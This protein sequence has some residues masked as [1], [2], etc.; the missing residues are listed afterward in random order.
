MLVVVLSAC[1]RTSAS[2]NIRPPDLYAGG[3]TVGDVRA[4]LG[5]TNWWPGPPSFGVR[6][7]NSAMT[8]IHERFSVTQR[9][10]HIGTTETF[11]AQYTLWDTTSSATTQMTTIQTAF[12]TSVTGPKE[13]DQVLYYGSQAS[14][15]APY[16][17]ATFVRVGQIVAG[18]D[19]S[20]KDGFPTVSQLG[21]IA[22]KAASRIKDA[23]ATKV[24]PSPLTI[25]DSSL[26]PPAGPDI[27]LLGTAKIPIEATVIQ[28]GASAPENLAQS[29]RDSGINDSVFGDYALDND[30]HME[31]RA[32]VFTFHSDNE[33]NGWLNVFRGANTLDQNGVAGFFDDASGQYFFLF[34][35]GTH[36]GMLVCR[37]TADT[38][39]ASRSC[40]APL[41]RVSV[42]WKTNL[43]G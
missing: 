15:A 38:E 36:G 16:A 35:S 31:V 39:A 42:A 18:I 9:F 6:P 41:S 32:S 37:S 22:A 7:L 1:T 3:L 12:G 28:I 25:D 5:D 43:G 23:L 8:P 4:L 21:R 27:T 20:R 33:A 14:G 13:G 29:F 24:H 19:W 34:T 11:V 30:T 40:E 17:T 26:L 10:A 2:A